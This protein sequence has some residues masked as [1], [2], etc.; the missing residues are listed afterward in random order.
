MAAY[1]VADV[2]ITDPEEYQRYARQVPPTLERYSGKFLVRG[3]QPETIEGGWNTKR[4]VIIE[5][6]NIEQAKAWYES[7]EYSSIAG[8]RHHSAHSRIVLVQG[9]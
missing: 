1:I 9:T 4:I 8:I 5:F 3:G 7:P 6:P 2:E